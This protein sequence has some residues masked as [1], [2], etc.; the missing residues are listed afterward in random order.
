MFLRQCPSWLVFPGLYWD[1]R[2]LRLVQVSLRWRPAAAPRAMRSNT[3]PAPGCGETGSLGQVWRRGWPAA[4]TLAGRFCLPQPFGTGRQ[5]LLLICHSST[6]SRLFLALGLTRPV[7]QFSFS[8]GF[9]MSQYHR[10][11]QSGSGWPNSSSWQPI[12][13]AYELHSGLQ[14]CCCLTGRSQH[15]GINN[16]LADCICGGLCAAGWSTDPSSS[17]LPLYL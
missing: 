15:V 1:L 4:P 6:K 16:T 3:E 17:R 10:S 12:K 2:P 8:F 13:G 14:T 9:C 5:S 7:F 11:S